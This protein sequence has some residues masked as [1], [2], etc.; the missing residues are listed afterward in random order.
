MAI[1]YGKDSKG[2]FP[3]ESQG[4]NGYPAL[5]KARVRQLMP[6]VIAWI[7]MIAFIMW[8]VVILI[9]MMSMK[10]LILKIMEMLLYDDNKELL[11]R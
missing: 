10:V 11:T 5:T 8:I 2:V 9:K 4:D 3:L 7:V 6:L 1:E